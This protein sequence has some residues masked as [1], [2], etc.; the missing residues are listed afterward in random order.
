[1]LENLDLKYSRVDYSEKT[2]VSQNK[3]DMQLETVFLKKSLK[4][5]KHEF[6][7]GFMVLLSEGKSLQKSCTHCKKSSVKDLIDPK[8]LES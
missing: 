3:I 8:A 1:M 2:R 4:Q 6:F 7:K 5:R